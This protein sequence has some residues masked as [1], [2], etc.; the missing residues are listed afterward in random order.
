M[1]SHIPNGTLKFAVVKANAYGHGAVAVATAI[2]MLL[3]D[4]AFPIL[5]KLSNFV[6]LDLAR[7]FSS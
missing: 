5:M 6:M 2:R 4:F 1:G 3:M 7:K